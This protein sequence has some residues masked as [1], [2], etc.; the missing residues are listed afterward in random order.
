MRTARSGTESLFLA[1][2]SDR[3]FKA[4][5]RGAPAD[6]RSDTLRL[7]ISRPTLAPRGCN[8]E[9]MFLRWY[10]LMSTAGRAQ[11]RTLS[12][13]A[14]TGRAPAGGT[15]A[16][17]LWVAWACHQPRMSSVPWGGR[18]PGVESPAC[19]LPDPGGAVRIPGS[20]GHV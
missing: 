17:A 1:K 11:S 20:C 3:M 10:S 8:R 15:P 2:G 5:V 19:L 14:G 18:G 16:A 6:L 13:P 12:V 9:R 4:T 7:H